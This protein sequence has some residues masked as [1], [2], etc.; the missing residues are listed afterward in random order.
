MREADYDKHLTSGQ[1]E[2][3]KDPEREKAREDALKRLE[4]ESRKP[5][6]ERKAPEYGSDKDFQ[7]IQ[8]INQLK[9]KP[10]LVSKTLVE[11]K[12]EKKEE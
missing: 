9:G 2:E 6:S 1:G 5:A 12:E 10:V 4:E 11:R 7:L 8:A 3:K